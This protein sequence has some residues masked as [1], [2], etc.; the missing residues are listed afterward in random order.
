MPL[1]II[2]DAPLVN[3]NTMAVPAKCKALVQVNT[4]EQMITALQHAKNEAWQ[5]LILGE[6]SNIL[7]T[8]D[9]P[10]L[11]IL[12]RIMGIE[13]LEDDGDYVLLRV[14][15]GENWHSLVEITVNN[16][17]FGLQNLALI[18]GLVGAAPVQNIGAYGCELKDTLESVTYLD[19]FDQTLVSLDRQQCQFSYRD[20]IFKNAL[21]GKSAITSVVLKLAKNAQLNISYPSLAKALEGIVEPTV[22]SVFDAV[23]EIRQSKLPSPSQIPNAG[24]FFKNPI[25]DQHLYQKIKQDYP[26]LPSFYLPAESLV[27]QSLK[28]DSLNLDPAAEKV[29]LAA[30]WL[31]EQAGWKGKTIDQVRV[32]Q[33][34]ALVIVNP[35]GADGKTVLGFARAV[36]KD[37][38]EKFGV[39][40]EIEPQLI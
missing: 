15:S 19:L 3:L 30:A 23:C 21:A 35:Q 10:G 13:V 31:I 7:F 28:T 17:W 33:D 9:Y 11:V 20:S 36:Q 1:N 2:F 25:V 34:Q 4:T 12:N 16:G 38:H 40:L 14:G 6:G 22:K 5:V 32:H 24:S 39:Q 29:K 8:Q 27:S 26:Q 18:P 37:I